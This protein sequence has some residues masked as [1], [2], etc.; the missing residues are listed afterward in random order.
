MRVLMFLPVMGTLLAQGALAQDCD[1]RLEFIGWPGLY[2]PVGELT[3]QDFAG[4]PVILTGAQVLEAE[5]IVDY[6]NNPAVSFRFTEQG[7]GIFGEFTAEN[8]GQP[9]AIVFN[10]TLMSAPRIMSPIP[11]GVGM[12]TGDFTPQ[13]AADMAHAITAEKCMPQPAS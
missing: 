5:A 1:Y 7:T 9:F 12:I 2:D 3:L 10:D 6:N 13:E 8:I 11:G 4:G